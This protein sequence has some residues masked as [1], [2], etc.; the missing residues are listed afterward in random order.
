MIQNIHHIVYVPTTTS[1]LIVQT[2][3]LFYSLESV[4]AKEVTINNEKEAGTEKYTIVLNKIE[5][6]ITV[7]KQ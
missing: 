1:K 3:F 4:S 7:T 2:I 6:F 5:K